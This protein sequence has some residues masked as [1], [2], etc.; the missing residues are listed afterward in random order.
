MTKNENMKIWDSLGKTDP[1]QTKQFKR[2]GGFQ[3]T[4]IKPMWAIK[5]M[6]EEFGPCGIGWGMNAPAFEWTDNGLVFC[7]V[8]VW[9]IPPYEAGTKAA[10]VY[11]VGGD[12]FAGER[13]NGT[14][15]VDDEAFKKAY[16]DATMNALKFIGV[17]ADVHMGLFDDSKYVQELKERKTTDTDPRDGADLNPIPHGQVGKTKGEVERGLREDLLDCKSTGDVMKVWHQFRNDWGGKFNKTFVERIMHFLYER[18]GELR[19]PGDRIDGDEADLVS[20]TLKTAARKAKTKRQL[21]AWA[22]ESVQQEAI[23][24]LP[25]AHFFIFQDEY[26]T[27]YDR[28]PDSELEAG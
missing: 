3:G 20:G 7:T 5:R 24:A 25:D 8:S 23:E 11:G 14:P 6:T 13:A 9:Y 15:F 18:T 17:G 28:L 21:Y 10:Y 19:K 16:T 4:A 22:A 1:D 2:P 12:K 27:L 26:R